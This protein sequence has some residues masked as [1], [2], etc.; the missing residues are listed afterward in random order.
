MVIMLYYDLGCLS[1]TEKMS[2]R[3][4]RPHYEQ[5]SDF[6]RGRMIGLKEAG[7]AN[8]RIARHMGRNNAVI[9]LMFAKMGGQ[10]QISAS[11]W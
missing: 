11:R 6:E 2:H 9:S 8:R 7:W 4:I 1:K 10:W 5:T 3:R